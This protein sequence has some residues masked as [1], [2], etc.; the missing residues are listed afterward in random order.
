M[1]KMSLTAMRVFPVGVQ[2]LLQIYS[3]ATSIL[4]KVETHQEEKIKK[5]L[6]TNAVLS[7]KEE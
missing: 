6:A 2:T 7:D 3:N 1:R 4:G 5:S